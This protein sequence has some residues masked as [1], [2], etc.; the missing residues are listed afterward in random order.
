MR[1]LHANGG[2][3]GIRPRARGIRSRFWGLARGFR[4]DKLSNGTPEF[5][6]FRKL[7]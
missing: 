3:S 1:D 7:I 4:I 2:F 6:R 5:L